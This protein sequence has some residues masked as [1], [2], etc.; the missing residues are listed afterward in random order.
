MAL[1]Q[2]S[3][4]DLLESMEAGDGG[5]L[6]RRVL[7]AMLQELVDAEATAAIGAGL[8]ERTETRTTRATEPAT[9]PWC[10]AESRTSSR[11]GR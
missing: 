3:L 11:A 8:H 4:V 6:M 7:A 2:S 10:P 1:D 5:A 9:R